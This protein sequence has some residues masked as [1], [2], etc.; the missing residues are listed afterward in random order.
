MLYGPEIVHGDE[1]EPVNT[2]ERWLY[3]LPYAETE[4]EPLSSRPPF[5]P[6]SMYCGYRFLMNWPSKVKFLSLSSPSPIYR[7]LP[8]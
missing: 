5:G 7:R 3:R 8:P 1:L 6:A 4:N 2:T